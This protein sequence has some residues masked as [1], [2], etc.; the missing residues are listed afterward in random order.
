MN[1][2]LKEGKI[3]SRP[4]WDELFMAEAILASSR[5]SCFNVHSGSVIVHDKRIIATGYNGAPADATSCIELGECYKE[6]V[7]GK[8]YT[9]TMNIGTCQ[10]VH[11]E[12]NALFNKTKNVPHKSAFLYT[13]VFPCNTCAKDIAGER[14][15][16]KIIYKRAYDER[17]IDNASRI[18]GESGI[19]IYQLNLS[20]ER[21]IDIIFNH[22]N[23]K[24][25]AWS[26]EEKERIL[27]PLE[28]LVK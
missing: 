3:G 20:P 13:T 4:G 7:T 24:F 28:L 27:K 9:D 12:K 16:G 2:E 17:E 19:E 25:G 6:K 21:C 10:G 14:S 1:G 8:N 11:S 22:S 23:V 5:A 26:K 15:V 18:F